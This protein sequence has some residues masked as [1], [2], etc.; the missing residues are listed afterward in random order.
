MEVFIMPRVSTFMYCEDTKQNERG[1]LEIINPL[2]V[3]Q[4]AFVPGMFSFSIVFGILGADPAERDY[5]LQVRFLSPNK[6]EQPLIDSGPITL[7][8]DP[9][10]PA[11]NL[12]QEAK[13]M[14]GNMDFRNVVLRNE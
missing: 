13:G 2:N 8:H 10:Q 14:M 7:G 6:D 11:T 1:Q 12:P 9:N 5:I 3:F 4:P